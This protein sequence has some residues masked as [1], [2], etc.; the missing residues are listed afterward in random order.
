MSE[1]GDALGV[2]LFSEMFA[3]E[4][5]ARG[6]LSRVLPP[7]MELSH[8][9]L[10]HHLDRTGEKTPAQLARAFH[11]TRGAITNTI[12]RL[13]TAGHVHV[14]P[15]WDDARR[16]FVS[17]TPAGRAAR[18]HALRAIEPV[19]RAAIAD[20]DADRLRAALPV[21]RELRQRLERDDG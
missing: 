9:S 5:L 19:I 11:L 12:G 14:R 6:R 16:K 8:F 2:A 10:L 15:D 17:I 1:P 4:Q 20:L 13:E 3:V 21:M 7:G 18:D